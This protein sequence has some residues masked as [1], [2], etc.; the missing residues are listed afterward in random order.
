MNYVDKIREYAS[1][2]KENALKF[3]FIQI[4]GIIS[5]LALGLWTL[6]LSPLLFV[7]M[8]LRFLLP[9]ALAR[10]WINPLIVDIA[11][12]WVGGILNWMRYVQ[13]LDIVI[14]QDVE[15]SPNQW[16]LIIANHQSWFDIFA[17][18]FFSHRRL[19][20]L[21]FFIKQELIWIPIAGLAW[22]ALDYPFMK[23]YSKK[24]LQK[25]PEKKGQ[26]LITTQ[27]ALQ[28]FAQQPT[29]IV[30]FLEGTRFNGKKHRQQ[31]PSYQHLLKPK[32]GGIAY[33]IQ[34]LG[35]RFNSVLDVT[36][37]YQQTPP[38]YW[39]M[40]CGQVGRV[41][42]GVT[43]RSI[44]ENFLTM[45]YV[46][47]VQERAAFQQWVSDIWQEKDQRLAAQSQLEK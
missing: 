2:W 42:V 38:S 26:D 46:A 27:R 16:N 45:D 30:N 17:L 37:H 10:R 41:H 1:F 19:P 11:Q 12:L 35:S 47:N 3:C 4:A 44:P 33:A 23:R 39:A 5:S 24:Y 29:S 8:L 18:L 36:I 40:A 14:E 43:K 25:H 22:W 20:I 9:A 13:R 21:K 6:A 15:L 7:T 31:K 32:A 28:K 34:T